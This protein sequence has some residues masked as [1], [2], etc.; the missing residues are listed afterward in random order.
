MEAIVN[1]NKEWRAALAKNSRLVVLETS[2]SIP[3]RLAGHVSESIQ[4]CEECD[5]HRGHSD[6]NPG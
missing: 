2:M 4:G 6:G 5:R 1:T 3:M